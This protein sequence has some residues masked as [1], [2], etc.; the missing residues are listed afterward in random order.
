MKVA[1]VHTDG[2]RVERDDQ[3]ESFVGTVERCVR[4]GCT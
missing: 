4:E 2:A 1:A 3:Q